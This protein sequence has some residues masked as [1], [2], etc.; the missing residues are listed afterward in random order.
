MRRGTTVGGT[1]LAAL[2]VAAPAA[3]QGAEMAAD[4]VRSSRMEGNLLQPRR[5]RFDPSFVNALRVPAGFRVNVFAS[6][7]EGGPRM[8]AVG[9]DGTVYVT[10][11][12]SGDVVAF[13]DRD[14]D[15]RADAMRKVVASL[16]RVHGIALHGETMYLATVRE[17]Y[18]ARMRP[19][20]TAEVPR[21]LV[22]DLPEGGQHPNRTLA[23]G[24][25]GMLYV[26]VGSTCNNCAETNPE[27]ATLLRMR[28]DGSG[29]GVFAPGLRNLIGWDWHPASGKLWGMDHGSDWRGDDLPPEELNRVENGTHYGWPF[30]YGDRQVDRFATAAPP[31]GDRQGFCRRTAAP[32]LTYTAHAAPIGMVFY[33]GA[34]F[35]AEWRGDA[36]VAMRGSWNRRPPSGYRLVRVR[37]DAQGNPQRFEDFVTGFLTPD[38]LA[39][40]A[41]LAG[42]AV[43]R[44]GSV[45]VT[46]DTNGVIYRVSYAGGSA[47][48]R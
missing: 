15:G 40:R 42:V 26:S 43:A 24:P 39:F 11:R 14:G 30:C 23:V 27:N 1:L 19:D 38:G 46:D 28:P 48:A 22:G 4:S 10:R 37:F 36:I 33:D 29:R 47:A 12:D 34:Q 9:G 5:L 32:V 8:M 35:P 44:D 31:D 7:V 17:L 21:L 2:L 45:L 6:G 16:P 18:A 20:G 41:R 13:S 25:D 3:G